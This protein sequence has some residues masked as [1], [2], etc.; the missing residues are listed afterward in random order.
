MPSNVLLICTDHWPAS[1]LGSAGHPNILSPTLD[2][3]AASG[4]RFTNAYSECPICIPARRT[5]MTGCSPQ[6][7]G[8]RSY[9]GT[10]LMPDLPTVAQ[11]FRD[12]GYQA[13]ASGKLHVYPQRNR[14]GFDEVMLGEEGRTQFGVTDDYETFLGDRGFAGQQFTNGMCNNDYLYRPWHLPEECHIT[15]WTTHQM[16][17]FI[18]R[19]D[20]R[21]PG[22]YYLSYCHPHPPLNPLADYL[23]MYRDVDPGLPTIGGWAANTASLPE[24][25]KNER[26]QDNPLSNHQLLW[27]RRA[28]YALCTHIDHQIRVV[29]GTLASE[30]LLDDTVICFTSDHGDMLGNHRLWG[31][32]LFYEDSANVPMIVL[33][34]NGDDRVGH[35]RV[36]DRLVGWQDVMPTMLDLAGV[37][38]PATCTGISMVGNETRSTLYGEINENASATRMIRDERHKLIYYPMG[39]V[40]QLFDLKEDPRECINVAESKDYVDVRR[41]LTDQ[42]IQEFYGGDEDWVKDGHLV[43]LP[44]IPYEPSPNRGLTGQRGSHWPVPPQSTQF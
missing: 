7:Q 3:L 19:R 26:N 20:P 6:A 32:S 18:Q 27:A 37:S 11:T 41:R 33:G 21:K 39:N 36:D 25:L 28:F 17:R 4:T 5:L 35:H 40:V 22:F 10:S 8:D 24:R 29:I 16:T 13:F 31:K 1:L 14:I 23:D 2:Q 12:A 30:G 9:K 34:A 43:G 38:I 44:D 15:N 42:L